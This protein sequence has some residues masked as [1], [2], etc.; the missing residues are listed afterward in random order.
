MEYV[1][2]IYLD[3]KDGGVYAYGTEVYAENIVEASKIV[4][5]HISNFKKSAKIDVGIY[6]EDDKLMA[7]YTSTSRDWFFNKEDDE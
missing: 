1:V 3:E 6:N 5:R 4:A 2:K 7:G